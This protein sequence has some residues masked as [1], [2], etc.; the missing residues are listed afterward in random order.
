MQLAHQILTGEVDPF[1]GGRQIASLGSFDCYD[2]LNEVDVVDEMAALWQ[3]VDDPEHRR[4]LGLPAMD[5]R[6][7][8][9][10]EIRRAARVLVE[11]FGPT[12]QDE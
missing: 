7:E 11:E 2:F 12:G 8:L 9:S 10:E 1:D 3:L 4:L 6:A 5:N